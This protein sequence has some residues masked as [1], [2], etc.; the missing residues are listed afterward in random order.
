MKLDH[1][2]SHAKNGW[3]VFPV[4]PNGK[5][6][7]TPNG[8]KDASKSVYV[9]EQ[10]WK[11]YPEANIGIATGQISNLAVVDVDVKNGAK[12]LESIKT[13]KGLAPTLIVKTP[14]GGWHYY[15]LLEKPLRSRNGLLPGVDLKADG[16]YVVAPGS[17]IDDIP[18]EWF[19]AEAHET[20][21]PD[22]I[23][24]MVETN[25]RKKGH[26]EPVQEG[27]VTEGTRN[28]TLASIGGTMRR[29]GLGY[30]EIAAALQVFNSKRCSPPL[31]ETEVDSIA[32]SIAKYPAMTVDPSKNGSQPHTDGQEDED[33][34]PPGFTDDSLALDFTKCHAGDW[35][36]VAAWGKW[37]Q[38]DG[39]CWR[40]E[41]TLRAYDLSRLVCRRAASKCENAKVA[42]K[43][44]SAST[45]AAVE[46]LARA[47]RKHAA[48]TEQWDS[49]PWLFNADNG[50]IDLKTG[51][52]RPHNRGLYMTKAAPASFGSACPAWLSFLNDV[53]NGDVDLQRY[54]ARVAG[55][56]LTGITVEHA[57]FFLYG[58]GANGKSVFVNTL[59]SIW[60]DYATNAPMDTFLE[61]RND[62]HPTDLASLRGAR[63]V[64]SI[65]V[66]DGKR[67]AESKIKSLTGGDKISARFMRQDFFEY[68]PQFK[69]LVAGN[70]KPSIRDVDVAMRRRLHL[71]PF[72][73]TIPPE[74]RDHN[75]PEKLLAE[76]DG[77]FG[78]AVQGCLEWQKIGLNPPSVVLMATEEYFQSE[79]ALGRW[80]NECC[81]ENTWDTATT[82]DLYASWKSWAE[83]SGE[84]IGSIKRLSESLNN[85]GYKRWRHPSND[86]MGFEGI[87]PLAPGSLK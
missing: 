34:R 1:A 87:A 66:E 30:E 67:W 12:G 13:V 71:I 11:K 17:T 29:R 55:Y 51:S 3:A 78:W 24:E 58:T 69:L 75:L 22:S 7:L 33:I 47:D 14:S 83:S 21:V 60:G 77:I 8:F 4:V 19:D 28:A 23:F 74:R 15:Y 76:R 86:R 54:L 10:W 32:V 62:R 79:D 20:A 25:G 81:T 43:V 59:A 64:T 82:Q 46:R 42:A 53:T 44:A 52:V 72:T 31:P 45:V 48:T 70:H 27:P 38:W 5:K 84:F 9:V 65:E 18:Y 63:L 37:L 41:A 35:R 56:A 39:A 6:P 68:K 2:L 80:I 49:D 57:L 36:Y 40:S 26:S 73:V 61:S 16:G 50:V 85:R